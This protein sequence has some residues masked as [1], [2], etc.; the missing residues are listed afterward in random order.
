MNRV[1]R[2]LAAYHPMVHVLLAGTAFITLSNSMSM[3]FLAIYLREATGLDY[4]DIGV[5]IGAGA[6]AA[7]MGGFVGGVLSDVFGRTRLMIGSL[8]LLAATY[9]G[10]VLTIDPLLLL[11]LNIGKGL[12]ASFFATIS[13][14]LMGDVT[15]QEKRYR[16]FANRYL[17]NNIGFSLGPLLGALL[18][19][20]GD[21]SGFY[22]TAGAYL[23]YAAALMLLLRRCRVQPL[24][25]A[26]A[27]RISAGSAWR[28]LRRDGVLL[29][30]LLGSI[31]LTTVHGQMS[32]PLSQYLK[33][34]F[35]DGV[36]LFALLMS[37]NGVT[38]IA[39]QIPLT[40]WAERFS[41]FQRIVLGSSLF[42]A[43]EVGFAF[44]TGWT[45]FIVSMIVFT[46]GEILVVP[47]EFA[48]LDEITPPGMRGTY[49]G[50]QSFSE[51]GSF[52]G[53]WLSGMLLS[54][55]GGTVMFLAMAAIAAGSLL[56]FA[57]GRLLYRR[58]SRAAASI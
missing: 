58:R 33:E 43:G 19:I 42:A 27:E 23:I 53:P 7:T 52:L 22:L 35:A 5:V 47:A 16:V 2:Y 24:E 29:L 40:R 14:A 8:L 18:G 30:F 38:V 45:G 9:A 13:K 44:S 56:F 49:Y 54:A 11:F 31:C 28:V 48:Q 20:S 37:I 15:P 32:V 26:G 51:L 17:A 25:E 21:A 39:A 34:R 50:A 57:Q 55:Y 1:R 41:L 12:G 36:V 10:L 4:A 46:A 6:L 3:P